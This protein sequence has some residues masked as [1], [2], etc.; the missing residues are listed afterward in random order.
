MKKAA[1]KKAVS[2]KI[3]DENEV[4]K[5]EEITDKPVE[6]PVQEPEESVSETEKPTFFEKVTGK[7]P[8]EKTEESSEEVPPIEKANKKLFLLG[9]GVFVATVIIT[10]AVGFFIINATQNNGKET[11]SDTKKTEISPSP[12]SE[13]KTVFKREEWSFEVLNG[14]GV[15]GAAAKAS[16]KLK[17]LGYKVEKVGNADEEVSVTEIYVSEDKKDADTKAMLS[18]LEKDFGKLTVTGKLTDVTA[19][20]RIVLGSE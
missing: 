17:A 5:F 20:V 14:S 15:I 16:D 1:P 3:K 13:P 4:P 18:D 9:A 6:V 8:V 12:T 11:T 19:S 7:K 2:K 10:G